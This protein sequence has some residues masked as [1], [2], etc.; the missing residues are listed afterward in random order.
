MARKHIADLDAYADELSARLNPIAGTL[1]NIFGHVKSNPKRVVFAEGE[2]DRM[3]RAANSFANSGLG[4]AILV[5]REAQIE[6]ALKI[7]AVELAENVEITNAKLSA[8]NVDYANYL[9]ERLQRNGFKAIT[10][11]LEF[12]GLCPRCQ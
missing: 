2:E 9:Y 3:I 12:F 8:R 7:S 10:H 11:R 5:G 4:K 6:E 1:Q